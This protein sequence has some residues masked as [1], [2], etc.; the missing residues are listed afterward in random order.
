MPTMMSSHIGQSNLAI[1]PAGRSVSAAMAAMD[2][3]SQFER[4]DSTVRLRFAMRRPCRHGPATNIG[5]AVSMSAP[6]AMTV[7][8]RLM[9]TRNSRA[10]M[11]AS[12]RHATGP[13]PRL[14]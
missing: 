8:M 13:E 7:R 1:A 14:N 6:T 2:A 12:C 11:T 10:V 3:S 9:L 5:T 4:N